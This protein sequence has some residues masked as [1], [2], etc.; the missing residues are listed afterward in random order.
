MHEL[1]IVYQ[2]MKTVD[3]IKIEQKVSEI[4]TIVL[5][6]GEM[7]DVVPKFIEEAWR[8]AAPQTDYKSTDLKVEVITARAKCADCGY[9]D[10]VK[11]L[12]F[13]CPICSSSNLK[14]ISGREFLI[15]E[16]VAK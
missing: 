6:I 1:G 12:S 3:G 2:L 13:S 16:I 9:E 14:I 5:Q 15:K 7:T 10:N 8:A 4:E 11:N